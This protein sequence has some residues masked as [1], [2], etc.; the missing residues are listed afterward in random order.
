MAQNNEN[1][2]K[3]KAGKYIKATILK[4]PI[5]IMKKITLISIVGIIIAIIILSASWKLVLPH[6]AVKN[7]DDKK[8]TPGAVANHINTATID[9]KGNIKYNQTAAEFWQQLEDDHNRAKTYLNSPEELAK[10]M[11]AET[12]TQFLDTRPSKDDNVKKKNAPNGY[13]EDEIDWD[14]IF[15]DADSQNIQGIVKLERAYADGSKRYLSYVTPE[16][17]QKWIDTYNDT[18]NSAEQREKAKENAMKHFTLGKK[19]E[20]NNYQGGDGELVGDTDEEKIWW[21]FMDIFNGNK[22]ATAAVMGNFQHESGLRPNNVQNN[23]EGRVGNDDAY[24]AKVNNGDESFCTDSAGYGLAQWTVSGRKTP[25]YKYVKDNNF[26]IDDLKAQLDFAQ[27][28]ILGTGPA[29]SYS[30]IYGEFASYKQQFLSSSSLDEATKIFFDQWEQPGD[31]SLPNRQQN[32]QTF[33]NRY[34]DKQRPASKG[35]NN[36]V[37]NLSSLKNVLVLG[38]SIAEGLKSKFE[39]EGA[40]VKAKTG[41]SAD[42]FSTSSL[43]SSK[44]TAVY[45][46]LG[47]NSWG[48]TSSLKTLIKNLKSKYSNTPIFVN[49]VIPMGSQASNSKKYNKCAT[50]FNNE[51][52]SYCSSNSNVYYSD[53]LSGY[54]NNVDS[55]TSSDSMKLHPNPAGYDVLFKNIKN[56]LISSGGSNSSGSSKPSSSSSS[57]S[58][59]SSNSSTSEKTGEDILNK[60]KE[61]VGSLK[62]KANGNNLKKGVDNTGFVFAVLKSLGL[63]SSRGEIATLGKS[64]GTDSSSLAADGQPGDIIIYNSIIAIY[65]GEGGYITGPVKKG[66]KVK[67]VA[68]A[69]KDTVV[70]IRRIGPDLDSSSSSSKSSKKSTTGVPLTASSGGVSIA[71]KLGKLRPE[72][73]AI[74]DKHKKDFNET[75]FSRLKTKYGGINNYLTNHLGGVFKEYAGKDKKIKPKTVADL[76]VAAEYVFGLMMI[77]GFDYGNGTA[78]VRWKGNDKFYPHTVSTA[79][80][81]GNI[82]VICAGK[83]SGGMRT[84]CNI[85]ISTLFKK[86]GVKKSPILIGKDRTKNYEVITNPEDLQPGDVIQYFR[87]NYNKSTMNGSWHHTAIV[88][89]VDKSKKK[90][91]TYDTG[92]YLQYHNTY[93]KIDKMKKDGS[94]NKHS[95]GKWFAVRRLKLE[96]TD[97]TSSE[98]EELDAREYVAKVPVWDENTIQINDNGTNANA[99]DTEYEMKLESVDYRQYLSKY[100]MPFDY[101]WAMLLTSHS[102]DFTFALADLVY[103]SKFV[104]TVFDNEQETTTTE[105]EKYTR[106]IT[107]K[108]NAT[109][110]IFETSSPSNT[111]NTTNTTS[112]QT[113]SQVNNSLTF[114]E[115]RNVEFTSVDGPKTYSN[116]STSKTKSNKI[117]VALTLADAWCVKHEEKFKFEKGKQE[118]SSNTTKLDDVKNEQESEPDNDTILNYVNSKLGANEKAGGV[119]KASSKTTTEE[120]NRTKTTVTKTKENKYT[121]V[122]SSTEGKYK[123]DQAPNF[124]TIFNSGVYARSNILTSG[125][126]VNWLFEILEAN[127]DTKDLVDLTKFFLYKATNKS[128]GITEFD[129]SVFDP[130]NFIKIS[131]SADGI[132]GGTV[133]EK[134]WVALK[135]L[136]VSDAAA[137][138]AMGNLSYESGGHG[139]HKIITEAVEGGT[140]IGIGMCQWSFGRRTQIENYA[141]SQGKSWKDEN[142]QI[143]FLIAE[144]TG[145]GKASSYADYQFMTKSYGGVTYSADSWRNTKDGKSNVE[146][147]TRSFAATFERPNASDYTSSMPARVETAKW[148]YDKFKGKTA[149]DFSTSTSGTGNGDVIKACEEVMKMF[150]QRDGQY[151]LTNLTYNNIEQVLNHDKYICCASY[152]SCVLYKSGAISKDIINKYNYHYT[153]DL[154]NMLQAAG[155]KQVSMSEIKAGDV[156]NRPGENSPGNQGHAL[157]YAGGDNYYDE[158]C[159]VT[160]SGGNPPTRSIK[161]GFHSR[162]AGNGFIAWRAPSK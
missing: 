8:N 36:A 3:E 99:N 150:L 93:K 7:K 30:G 21:Y 118:T 6:D 120:T 73:Q 156:V 16:K 87:S 70:D 82:E 114:K 161:S 146:Y 86:M 124:V 109:V 12:V 103:N 48:D 136:G 90:V 33:Y 39:S 14:K 155:Y 56:N 78:N 135:N 49:S 158:G 58:D 95:K 113:T 84:C 60:A 69:K 51:M 68:D 15:K 131:E 125:D 54:S 112:T 44:P 55:Y 65:D 77:Y 154:P 108:T 13:L 34:K 40:T 162:Y 11:N 143:E 88:G 10:L 42:Y 22:I 59:S 66:E 27:V 85:G 17:M 141:K 89:E 46:I 5:R 142:I 31:S 79:Y 105:K 126:E 76:Q 134:V 2:L 94:F 157:I 102:K 75:N 160:S 81:S 111:Q 83:R 98:D 37:G 116:E 147:A 151:S 32:A 19:E 122:K 107:T 29:S 47:Q 115:L 24:T 127:D 23:Q 62:Y 52:K 9:E 110:R 20:E 92:G 28:E 57:S 61:Y 159:C 1:D 145:K 140:G 121:Q 101:L 100:T 128:Y 71:P 138:G 91:V 117:S 64:I 72:T 119:T 149:K 26:K 53:V 139:K 41:V 144:L 4:K 50:S 35:G 123:E 129:F 137:A 18:S 43:P 80:S 25:L 133:E 74:I 97:D 132:V 63:A 67:Q 104:L 152:V 38:D 45:L 130:A 153:V 106:T 148:F 96:G